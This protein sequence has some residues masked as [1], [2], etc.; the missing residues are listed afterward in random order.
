M[1]RSIKLRPVTYRDLTL[2]CKPLPLW[3][4]TRSA[5]PIRFRPVGRWLTRP[6]PSQLVNGVA[7]EP[8]GTT[9][10]DSYL[11]PSFRSHYGSRE[12]YSATSSA[13]AGEVDV[14]YDRRSIFERLT[15]EEASAGC[16][17]ITQCPFTDLPLSLALRGCYSYWILHPKPFRVTP[18]FIDKSVHWFVPNSEAERRF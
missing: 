9:E 11:M 7:Q 16:T 5:Q 6:A 15:R 8:A 12:A 10:A 14:D 18:V 13:R 17:D 4:G 2:L 1:S 3:R